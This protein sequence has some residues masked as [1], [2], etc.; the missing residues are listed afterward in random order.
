MK[1]NFWKKQ[2]GEGW[3]AVLADLLS[4][5]YADKLINK[6]NEEYN[7]ETVFPEKTN[8]F[9]AFRQTP[10]EDL[11]VVILGQDPYH[12]GS[13]TGLAFANTLTPDNLKM[14]PSLKKIDNWH[15]KEGIKHST[16]AMDTSLESWASQ[17]V[18]MLNTALT[19]KQKE[20]GSHTKYWKKFT[21]E[22]LKTIAE[23]RPDCIF[24]LWGNHAKSFKPLIK[25]GIVLEY[26][27]PAYASYR[28]IEWEC[29]NFNEANRI[30]E[31]A[32]GPEFQ[33]LW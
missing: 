31:G 9:R 21:H 33:I 14:S 3:S 24:M 12:D 27:H 10:W 7:T 28:G 1:N 4:S 30:I 29:P 11:R 19:V 20:A 22:V 23:W 17:G 18:L 26:V 6:L 32:N 8:V 2:L 5:E 13:A 16:F 15:H 25:S